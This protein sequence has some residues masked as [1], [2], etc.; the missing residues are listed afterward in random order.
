MD[1]VSKL[2]RFWCIMFLRKTFDP[3]V[4]IGQIKRTFF[5]E[6]VHFSRPRRNWLCRKNLIF[7]SLSMG[8]T[9]VYIILR[10]FSWISDF[11]T[12]PCLPPLTIISDF[13]FPW[14]FKIIY[15]LYTSL[16]YFLSSYHRPLIINTFNRGDNLKR[17]TVKICSQILL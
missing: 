4:T 7:G 17:L 9:T 11:Y 8:H 3:L 15:I 5:L 10:N 16:T 13:G 6:F 14:N 12:T 2:L 1:C